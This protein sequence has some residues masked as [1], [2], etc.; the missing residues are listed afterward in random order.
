MIRYST[1][2]GATW[3]NADRGIIVE[4]QSDLFADD[5]MMVAN[6]TDEGLIQDVW[7]LS[8][9]VASCTILYDDWLDNICEGE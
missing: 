4:I 9:L 3:T 8:G 6:F 5:R 7:D 1:D 2:N